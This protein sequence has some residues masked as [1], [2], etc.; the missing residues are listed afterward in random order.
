M[1]FCLVIFVIV[2]GVYSSPILDGLHYYVTA[3]IS[4]NFYADIVHYDYF[5]P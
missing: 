3:L 5:E 4:N 2:F 1:L